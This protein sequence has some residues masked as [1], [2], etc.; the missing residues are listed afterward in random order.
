MSNEGYYFGLG[1][2]P[3]IT[4]Q[5]LPEARMFPYKDATPCNS[6]KTITVEALISTNGHLLHTIAEA[7]LAASNGCELCFM[8]VSSIDQL[9]EIV[10]YAETIT[11]MVANVTGTPYCQDQVLVVGN[12]PPTNDTPRRLHTVIGVYTDEGT[13]LLLHGVSTHL[14]TNID[15]QAILQET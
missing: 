7:I 15:V 2:I 12:I 10:S 1:V 9:D 5:Q 8:I 13:L 6:C 14:M 11:M 4:R 3:P